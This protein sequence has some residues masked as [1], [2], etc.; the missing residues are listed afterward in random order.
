MVKCISQNGFALKQLKQ[1]Y[2]ECAL[3]KAPCVGSGEFIRE[4][5]PGLGRASCSQV[6]TFH[7]AIVNRG[8]ALKK[9][10]ISLW[11][12]KQKVKVL[13]KGKMLLCVCSGK[14]GPSHP[15]HIF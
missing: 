6:C 10:R 9:T 4:K 5:Y 12:L 15:S 2:S 1:N 8:S 14:A 3:T 11:G 7:S 13:L